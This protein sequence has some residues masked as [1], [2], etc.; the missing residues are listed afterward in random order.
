[1]TTDIRN[2]WFVEFGPHAA[3]PPEVLALLKDSTLCDLSWHN[4]VCASFMITQTVYDVDVRLWIHPADPADR[5]YPDIARYCVTNTIVDDGTC[6]V[7]DDLVEALR[8]LRIE[9]TLAD[10]RAA[11]TDVRRHAPLVDVRS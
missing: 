5:E 11:L 6:Y 8:I 3:P 7:G 9:T 4:D 1:M 10:A 2:L